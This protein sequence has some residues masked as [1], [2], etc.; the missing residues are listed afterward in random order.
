MVF[1][2]RT[3][4]CTPSEAVAELRHNPHIRHVVEAHSYDEAFRAVEQWDGLSSE[5]R[6]GGTAPSG[7]H[8]KHVR[9]MMAEELENKFRARGAALRKA[10]RA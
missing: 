2:V 7:R 8:V 9:G 3:M 10:G 1:L 6:K 5:Q 4:N